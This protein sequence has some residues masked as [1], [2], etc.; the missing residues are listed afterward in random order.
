LQPCGE[1]YPGCSDIG[2]PATSILNED[3]QPSI[4]PA[5][6]TVQPLDLES[7]ALLSVFRRHIT[8]VEPAT[9]STVVARLANAV[10]GQDTG[11]RNVELSLVIQPLEGDQGVDDNFL[12]Q[13][14]ALSGSRSANALRA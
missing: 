13:I 11:V 14:I 1:I 3:L 7:L 5:V 12:D 6:E 4:L 8:D 10:E 9:G 2:R